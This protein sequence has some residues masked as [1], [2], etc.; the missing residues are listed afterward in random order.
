MYA[1]RANHAE[2][3][4]LWAGWL[5]VFAAAFALY[6]LTA[7]RGAQWQDSGA[8]ILRVVV[9]EA[10]HP[11]GLALS[12]PLHHW[13]GRFV[14]SWDVLEPCFAITLISALAA[15]VA[16]ANTYGCVL[17]LTRCRSAAL[18]AAGSLGLAHTFWQM[19]TLA[20]TYTL[21][22][23]LLTGECWCVAAYASTRRRGFLWAALLL[24]G[25][26]IA[27]HLLAG[28]TTPV[29]VIVVVYAVWNNDARVKDA[30]IAFGVWLLGSLPYTGLVVSELLRTGDWS[31][32][33][34]SAL[35]GRMF[36]DE[37]LNTALSARMLLIGVGFIVLNFPNLLLPAAAYGVVRAGWPGV[38]LLARRALLAGIIVHAVFAFRYDI[39]DQHTFFL[40]MYVLLALF[41]GMGLAAVFRIPSMRLR[42]TVFVCAIV[43]VVLTPCLYAV[44]PAVAR[45]FDVL[46][47]VVRNKPYRDDYVYVFTPW[48]VVERSADKMSS[49]AVRLAGESGLIL[50]EDSMAEFAV[51]YRALRAGR[52]GLT[53]TRHAQTDKIQEAVDEARPV[54]LVP[55]TIDSPP[56]DVR[57]GSWR[58]IGDLYILNRK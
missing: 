11:L 2:S 21:V 50:V 33:L 49:Q 3:T 37:V 34:H 56:I 8:H 47:S 54:V 28:L 13:L 31:G 41:G 43:G 55:R 36:A 15:A 16:V 20:E 52:V 1:R 9:G 14:I 57:A 6:A 7:N 12:H 44:V 45:R 5:A 22:A 25:L 26:G 32:T 35:F 38:P 10:V 23:A 24:N 27:N 30:A 58:R 42:R 18:F 48:S 51:R 40:P 46:G 19:A 53:I 4:S 29:L 17:T 39:I